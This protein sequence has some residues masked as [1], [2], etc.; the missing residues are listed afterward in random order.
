MVAKS[1]KLAVQYAFN[2]FFGGGIQ[3]IEDGSFLFGRKQMVKAKWQAKLQIN[4]VEYKLRLQE[5]GN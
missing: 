4:K 1:K 5:S 3:V 2:P